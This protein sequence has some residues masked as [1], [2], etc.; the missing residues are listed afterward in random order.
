MQIIMGNCGGLSLRDTTNLAHAYAF[1]VCQN[2]SYRLYRFDS[3]SS[4]K[5]LYSGFTSIIAKGLNQ[6]NIIAAVINGNT[7]DLYINHRQVA[8]VHDNAYSQGLFGVSAHA[9]TEVAYT[10]A[11]MWIL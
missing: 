3:F 5:S 4:G 1:D 8:S 9:H 7:F 2:G 11:K 10:H 6:S